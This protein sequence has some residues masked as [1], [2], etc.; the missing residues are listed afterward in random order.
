MAF[1]LFIATVWLNQVISPHQF[2]KR[3]ISD[4]L[5]SLALL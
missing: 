5:L 2:S 3:Q 4:D 1:M